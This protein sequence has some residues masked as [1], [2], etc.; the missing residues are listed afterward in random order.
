MENTDM[1]EQIKNQITNEYPEFIEDGELETGTEEWLELLQLTL[2][3]YG[4]DVK[5]SY[6]MLNMENM[7]YWKEIDKL[8][9]TYVINLQIALDELKIDLI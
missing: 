8:G 6:D 5:D 4:I 1:I 9:Y 7:P 3:L 2:K